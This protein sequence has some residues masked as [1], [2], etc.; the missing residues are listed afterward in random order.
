MQ[1]T[2]EYLQFLITQIK[3]YAKKGLLQKETAIQTL[4]TLLDTLQTL[5]ITTPTNA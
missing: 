4:E 2:D 5:P 1:F 3:K